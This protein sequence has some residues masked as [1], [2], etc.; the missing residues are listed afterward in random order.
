VGKSAES[1]RPTCAR[2]AGRDSGC[3]GGP[4]TTLADGEAW[5]KGA[6]LRCAACGEWA[7]GTD[8]EL[9][10]AR[11]ADRA[12]ERRLAAENAEPMPEVTRRARA[13]GREAKRAQLALEVLDAG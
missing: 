12:L 1:Q 7:I 9:E 2:R 13:R 6:R 3:C 8:D 4:L 10:R 11:R 5:P